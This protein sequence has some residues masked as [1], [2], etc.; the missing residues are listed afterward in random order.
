MTGQCSSILFL[1]VLHVFGFQDAFEPFIVYSCHLHNGLV[2]NGYSNNVLEH[3]HQFVSLNIVCVC[4]QFG[5]KSFSYSSF[6][7]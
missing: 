4:C 6:L 5:V 1:L 3:A 2:I 7:L